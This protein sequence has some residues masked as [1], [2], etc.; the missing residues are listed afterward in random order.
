MEQRIYKIN[1]SPKEGSKSEE[2]IKAENEMTFRIPE[3]TAELT[4]QAIDM[5]ERIESMEDGEER[6]KLLAEVELL[7]EEIMA[8]I[9]AEKKSKHPEKLN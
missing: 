9:T 8:S 7:D 2:E 5:R 4:L 1:T 3:E 6:S